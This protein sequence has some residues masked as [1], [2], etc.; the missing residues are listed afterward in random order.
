MRDKKRCVQRI[1]SP[2]FNA[3]AALVPT[4]TGMVDAGNANGLLER[5]QMDMRFL[6][7]KSMGTLSKIEATT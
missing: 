2:E 3:Q 4:N 6:S 7:D 5:H 1:W